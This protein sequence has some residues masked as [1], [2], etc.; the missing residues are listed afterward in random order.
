MGGG[1]ADVHL[2]DDWCKAMETLL[3]IAHEQFTYGQLGSRSKS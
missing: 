1:Q 3:R 2:P